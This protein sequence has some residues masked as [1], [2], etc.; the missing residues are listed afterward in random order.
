MEK[1]TG[2]LTLEEVFESDKMRIMVES[3]SSFAKYK[4]RL[5]T[6]GIGEDTR[7]SDSLD[8]ETDAYIYGFLAE[9]ILRIPS[10]SNKEA[11]LFDIFDTIDYDNIA[12]VDLIIMKAYYHFKK[13]EP[14]K[15]LN[16][17][18]NLSKLDFE[19]SADSKEFYRLL[20]NSPYRRLMIMEAYLYKS[21]Q[22]QKLGSGKTEEAFNSS[23]QL[24]K[25]IEEI[26]DSGFSETDFIGNYN[27]LIFSPAYLY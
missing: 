2:N 14:E 13:N 24:L 20:A 22:L 19:D 21:Y 26:G 8:S 4:E 23:L 9:I 25:I 1:R 11:L 6:L 18:R 12:S 27:I 16:T 10:Q 3:D 7:V 15:N 5:N 17:L